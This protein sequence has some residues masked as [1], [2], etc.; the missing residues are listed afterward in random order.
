[1]AIT[2]SLSDTRGL[3]ILNAFPRPNVDIE[4]CISLA[5]QGTLALDLMSCF[6]GNIQGIDAMAAPV[7]RTNLVS[8][9]MSESEYLDSSRV[10]CQLQDVVVFEKGPPHLSCS[11]TESTAV[12]PP[13]LAVLAPRTTPFS[14]ARSPTH[15]LCCPT[16]GRTPPVWGWWLLMPASPSTRKLMLSR[17]VKLEWDPF[18]MRIGMC[19]DVF[20]TQILPHPPLEWL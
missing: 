2:S 12:F 6:A 10:M 16:C 1:M 20:L 17:W 14:P 18:S 19:M 8:F 13:F 9:T 4:R 15:C 5:E 7:F 3:T 11:S